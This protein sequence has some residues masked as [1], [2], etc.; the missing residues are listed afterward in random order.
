MVSSS[1]KMGIHKFFLTIYFAAV[2]ASVDKFVIHS[3]TRH[4]HIMQKDISSIRHWNHMF[5]KW[6]V[7]AK[8][9]FDQG[10]PLER[11][12][13]LPSIDE[14]KKYIATFE[15]AFTKVSDILHLLVNDSA[16]LSGRLKSASSVHENLACKG[17]KMEDLTDIIGF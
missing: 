13:D 6:S 14:I 5:V 12:T 2:V 16:V 8:D 11:F 3:H 7:E 4:Y 9:S 10:G 1:P 17:C 15:P